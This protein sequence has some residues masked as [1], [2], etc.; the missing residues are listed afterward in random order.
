MY[1][2]VDNYGQVDLSKLDKLLSYPTKLVSI[3]WGQ[4]EIG[5]L[6]PI[7]Y[8]GEECKETGVPQSSSDWNATSCTSIGGVLHQY[9]SGFSNYG[10]GHGPTCHI[11]AKS[12]TTNSGEALLLYQIS[13]ITVSTTCN[14]VLASTISGIG[15]SHAGDEY[16]IVSGSSM[17]CV[18]DIVYTQPY[19]ESSDDRLNEQKIWSLVYAIQETVVV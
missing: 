10:W 7:Q 13:S 5:T 14:G 17:P 16:V 6:Q 8:I 18:H 1:W 4:S 9:S 19:E 2:P 3:I 12:I 11:T 15:S